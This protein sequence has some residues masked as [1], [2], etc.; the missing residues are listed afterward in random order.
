MSSSSS[1]I[2][3][4]EALRARWDVIGR[5]TLAV[6]AT[7]G[8]AI[9]CKSQVASLCAG[10]SGSTQPYDTALGNTES[11]A[12][13][14]ARTPA[15]SSQ[16]TGASNGGSGSDQ[17]SGGSSGGSSAGGSSGSQPPAPQGRGAQTSGAPPRPAAAPRRTAAPPPQAR[18]P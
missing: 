10:A 6:A 17:G 4:A 13:T 14:G 11:F 12:R 18:P 9:E 16:S 15:P 2:A 1:R 5:W 7:V 3:A 8:L